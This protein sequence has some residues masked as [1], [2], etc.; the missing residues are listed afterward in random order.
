MIEKTSENLNNNFQNIL[1][2]GFGSGILSIVL[3][4]EL[5]IKKHPILYYQCNIKLGATA[6]NY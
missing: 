5:G 3:A 1:E 2:I 4:K 6:I